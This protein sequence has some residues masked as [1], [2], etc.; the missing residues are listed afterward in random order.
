[1]ER[2][3]RALP[4]KVT[5]VILVALLLGACA[6]AKTQV[7]QASTEVPAYPPQVVA[8]EPV[9][10]QELAYPAPVA[11]ASPQPTPRSQ[12]QATDPST[13]QLASG[14][15]QLVEFF[16]NW[17]PTCQAMVPVVHG[18]ES[19]YGAKVR[20]VYLDVDD[21]ATEEFKR[22]L[23]YRYQPHIFLLDGEGNVLAQWVGMVTGDEL[24]RA[25]LTALNP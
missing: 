25:I 9:E 19:K 17:C 24:E 1:M 16:A 10:P 11:E 3:N 6:V 20:F 15:I 12:L 2:D 22:D 5:A 13:V 21:P 8:P 4:G 23:G 18:L 7:S 14:E